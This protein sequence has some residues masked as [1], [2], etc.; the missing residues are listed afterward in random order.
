MKSTRKLADVSLA[1]VC[2]MAN[3]SEKA[4]CFV[5]SVLSNCAELGSKEFFAIVDRASTDDTREVLE[6]H[7]AQVPE[8]TVIWAAEN[9]DVVDAYKRGY[10]EAL[11]TSA[12]WILEIDAGFSHRPSDIPAMLEKMRHGYDCVFGS[13]FCQGGSMVESPWAR[14]WLSYGGTFVT[15]LFLG[16]K[17]SDMTS[18]FQLFARESLEMVLRREIKSHGPFFQTEMK[19]YCRRLD[20]AEVP[21]QYRAPTHGV[22]RIAI[23]DALLNLMRLFQARLAGVL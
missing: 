7:A 20:V 17:L 12:D 19:T 22:G 10:R 6:R 4:V 18:G 5:D 2:P 16:T 9:R 15:N 8:L 14:Y 23:A 3:E 1:I 11:Q 13:R 21:I